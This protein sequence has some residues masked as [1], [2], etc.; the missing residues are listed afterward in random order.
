MQSLR[1]KDSPAHITSVQHV[2]QNL[3]A[4]QSLSKVWSLLFDKGV[5]FSSEVNDA[6]GVQC[7]THYSMLLFVI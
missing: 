7:T 5:L 4:I 6:M 2:Q 3:H 1:G